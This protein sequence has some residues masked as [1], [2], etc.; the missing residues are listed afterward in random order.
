[1]FEGFKISERPYTSFQG[2]CHGGDMWGESE[3]MGFISGDTDP[4][5]P[6]ADGLTWD[7]GPARME[8]G[9]DLMVEPATME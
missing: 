4:E 8:F 1:M 5:S 7:D 6:I 3:I 2:R 9:V